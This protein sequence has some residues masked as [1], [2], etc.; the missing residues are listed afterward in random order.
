MPPI[1]CHDHLR[2]ETI[3]RIAV[4]VDDHPE[5]FPVNYAIDDS[6]DIYFRTDPGEKANVVRLR[7]TKITGRRIYRRHSRQEG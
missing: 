7:P 6:G 3:G 2:T 4:M 1:A 5:I